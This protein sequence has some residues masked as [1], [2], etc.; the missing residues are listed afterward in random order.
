MSFSKL[1]ELQEQASP[2]PWEVFEDIDIAITLHIGEV[3]KYEEDERIEQHSEIATLEEGGGPDQTVL[4]LFEELD[5]VEAKANA[6][7]AAL[8]PHL[9][10]LAEALEAY[11]T[12]LAGRNINIKPLRE[13]NTDAAKALKALQEALDE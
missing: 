3:A 1:S 13:A 6:K 7:L 2:G 9:L 4:R 5:T 11:R 10:P 8:A 12:A